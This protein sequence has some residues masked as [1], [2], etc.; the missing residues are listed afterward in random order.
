MKTKGFLRRDC[1][2][3]ERLEATR[4]NKNPSDIPTPNANTSTRCNTPTIIILKKLWINLPQVRNLQ[5]IDICE[6]PTPG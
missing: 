5:K 3:K 6:M 1:S 4:P 2:N